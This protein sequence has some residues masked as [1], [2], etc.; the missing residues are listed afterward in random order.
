MST[1][2]VTAY[3]GHHW[4]TARVFVQGRTGSEIVASIMSTARTEKILW[5]D[6]GRV[7]VAAPPLMFALEELSRLRREHLYGLSFRAAVEGELTASQ[8][9]LLANAGVRFVHVTGLDTFLQHVQTVKLLHAVAIDLSWDLALVP[10]GGD[11]ELAATMAKMHHL[12]PPATVPH[13]TNPIAD[14][15]IRW[16]DA[17]TPWTLTYAR[18]ADFLRIRDRRAGTYEWTFTTLSARQ[19][20]TFL[21]CE[22][23]RAFDDIACMVPSV[24]RVKL[25]GFL[26]SLVDRNLMCRAGDRYQALAIRRKLEERWTTAEY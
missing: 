26:D 16:K 3:K 14:A 1:A 24:P 18:G 5:F 20:E 9:Q 21:F 10:D 25:R 19:A 12:P 13:Q 22:E 6:L 2:T 17:H 4:P 15:V 7:D 11:A 23:T 8:A